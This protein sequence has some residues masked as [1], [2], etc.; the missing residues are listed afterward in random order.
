MAN[1]IAA[2]DVRARRAVCTCF[3]RCSPACLS[4]DEQME[5]ESP[6]WTGRA[7]GQASAASSGAFAQRTTTRSSTSAPVEWRGE[8]EG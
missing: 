6:A 1:S 5:P 3:V 2:F 8:V 7:I 4:A